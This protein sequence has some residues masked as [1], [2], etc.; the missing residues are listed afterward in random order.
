MSSQS[1]PGEALTNQKDYRRRIYNE[2]FKAFHKERQSRQKFRTGQ[3][4]ARNATDQL[5]VLRATTEIRVV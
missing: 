3:S 2:L 4:M 5:P 1:I